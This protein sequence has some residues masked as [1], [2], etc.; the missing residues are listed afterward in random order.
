MDK[1]YLGEECIVRRSLHKDDWAFIFST[2]MKGMRY[3]HDFY[4]MIPAELF[5]NHMTSMI[6]NDLNLAH[7][8]VAVFEKDPDVI[9]GYSVWFFDTLHWIYV[10]APWRRNKIGRFLCPDSIKYM[11]MMTL[12]GK[13]FMKPEWIFNP[14]KS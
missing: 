5:H 8:T 11:S 9:L 6:E 1:L 12:A 13:E 4:Q 7:T 10:K 3:S 2:W 14:F